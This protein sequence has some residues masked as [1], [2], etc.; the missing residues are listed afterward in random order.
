MK[1]S[2]SYI[3]KNKCSYVI[4]SWKLILIQVIL[5]LL[6][7]SKAETISIREWKTY[8]IDSYVVLFLVTSGFSFIRKSKGRDELWTLIQ[9][10]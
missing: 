2:G 8:S 6:C 4:W 5:N 3:N 7:N 10:I 1:L 9:W